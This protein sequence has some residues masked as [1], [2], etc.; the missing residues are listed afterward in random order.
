MLIVEKFDG[1]WQ[2][3]RALRSDSPFP[4]TIHD[5][6]TDKNYVFQ[7]TP[8]HSTIS[9][10]PPLAHMSV[11]GVASRTALVFA[12]EA[13]ALHELRTLHHGESHEMT[14]QNDFSAV[15]ERYRFRHEDESA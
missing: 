11:S 12:G 1:S 14:L 10:C 3:M 6:I 15:P 7:T 9:E 4:G 2:Q 5:R 13:P 8:N